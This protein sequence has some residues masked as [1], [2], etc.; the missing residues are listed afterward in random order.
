MKMIADLWARETS[1]QLRKFIEGTW[2]DAQAKEWSGGPHSAE[3][4][5]REDGGVV[6]FG[7]TA[8]LRRMRAAL[9]EKVRTGWDKV[10]QASKQPR[11]VFGAHDLPPMLSKGQ[12]IHL[13]SRSRIQKTR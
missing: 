2:D 13:A 9:Q 5:S 7:P 8:Q 1:R 12:A 10:N 11:G 3:S 4:R 6:R